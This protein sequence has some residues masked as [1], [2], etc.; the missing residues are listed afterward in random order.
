LISNEISL[1]NEEINHILKEIDVS[2]TPQEA[3]SRLKNSRSSSKEFDDWC[4]GVLKS[5]LN[6]KSVCD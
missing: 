4:I 5:A 2:A 3:L 6:N 1:E